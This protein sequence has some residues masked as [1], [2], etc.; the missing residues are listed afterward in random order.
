MESVDVKDL[1]EHKTKISY[2]SIRINNPNNTV[3][4]VIQSLEEGDVQLFIEYNGE[5]K[6]VLFISES[7]LNIHKLLRTCGEISFYK[8]KDDMRTV[9]TIEQ[10]LEYM[11]E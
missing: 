10:Y 4:L 1:V 2:P 7:A 8:S 11:C 6:S 5:R 3:P 9:T